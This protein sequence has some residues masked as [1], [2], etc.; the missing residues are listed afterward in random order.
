MK[1]FLV[2]T[3]AIVAVAAVASTAQAADPI[4]LSLGGF[5]E[6]WV[7]YS[8]QNENTN[9]ANQ[10]ARNNVLVQQDTE[11]YFRGNTKLDNG[12]TVGVNIDKEA[13]RG[14]TGQDDV[15]VSVSSDS[16]GS[17]KL[18][19]TKGASY[20]LSHTAPDVGI[21][22]NDGDVENWIS[23]TVP[24]T[25]FDNDT[26]TQSSDG[27]KIVYLTPNFGG[28]QAG[29]S[30]GLNVVSASGVVDTNTAGNDLQYNLGVAYNG[31]FGGVSVGADV[32][33]EKIDE[34][35]TIATA[36]TAGD[37][38]TLRGGVS[39]GVAGFTIGG[40]LAKTSNVA[41]VNNVDS[42]G[43]DLGVS[44]AT[45]PYAVSASYMSLEIDQAAGSSIEDTKKS[46][47]LS[48]AYDLGAGVK[49][50]TSIFGADFD[51]T[52]ATAANNANDN[53]GFGVV[54]GLAISF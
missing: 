44:Y 52:S 13:D 35:G 5:A 41:N 47:M 19:A 27:Q 23:D 17:I 15:F 3:T 2:A 39:V 1:K 37:E 51:D 40:S 54:A 48:G 21:G 22:H 16:M 50:K 46:W 4:K 49:A 29:A 6:A 7:G 53:D 45:G 14:A 38:K 32:N 31:D 26:L 34:K 28:F 30:Y 42:S 43:W 25:S 20:G 8:D 36:T 11:V 18:G 33:Y 10:V 24:N 12:L 9:T